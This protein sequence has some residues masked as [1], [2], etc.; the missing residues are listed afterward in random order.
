MYPRVQSAKIN[1]RC[2]QPL[3]RSTLLWGAAKEYP[4]KGE[5]YVYLLFQKR[6]CCERVYGY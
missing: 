2:C 3:G 4:V 5:S 1:G 6:N